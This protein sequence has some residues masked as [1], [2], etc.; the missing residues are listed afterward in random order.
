MAPYDI[1]FRPEDLI[2]N[3]VFS[4]EGGTLTK[5][6]EKKLQVSEADRCEHGDPELLCRACGWTTYHELCTSYLPRLRMFHVREN[7]GLWHMGND[8]LIWDRPGD[9]GKGT[10]EYMTYKF[11]RDQETK[12]IPLVKEMYQ[13][14]KEGDQFVFTVMSRVKGVTLESIWTK[15]TLEE[16]RSYANQLIAALRE[17]RQFTAPSPQRVDSSPL[18]DDIVG[19]CY[20]SKICKTIPATREEWLNNVDEEIRI[21]IKLQM[22]SIQE[23]DDKP[24]PEAEYE[25][26]QTTFPDSAPF[27]LTHSD[28]NMGNIMVDD[29]RILAIIDWEGAGYYPWWVERWASYFRAVSSNADELFDMVWAELDPEVSRP[30]FADKVFRP[31]YKATY[32]YNWAPT[33]HTQSHD[34]WLRPRCECKPIGGTCAGNDWGAEL[35]HVV[36]REK[37]SWRVPTN[38]TFRR[39]V[40][41]EEEVRQEGGETLAKKLEKVQL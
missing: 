36:K 20:T 3:I 40:A 31:V 13:F 1:G 4:P 15:L 30:E 9:T 2:P 24:S 22:K 33:E 7:A 39:E 29:G 19:Q 18:R 16:K 21:G 41:P 5:D 37:P 12:D 14:G 17:L 25:E 38:K 23:G 32:A 6:D 28:L 8:W 35:N 11:L 34:V 26:I 10:N 27:V